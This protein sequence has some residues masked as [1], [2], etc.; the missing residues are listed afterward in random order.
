[1]YRIKFILYTFL[2]LVLS[3]SCS[4]KNTDAT[5][6]PDIVDSKQFNENTPTPSPIINNNIEEIIADLHNE[7]KILQAELSYQN[8]GINKIEAQ[9]Q[10]WA[11]PLSIYNKE[12]VLNNGSSIFGKIIYQDENVMKIETLIGQLM[13]ERKT[14]ARVINQNNSYNKLNLQPSNLDI[15]KI[16]FN[17]IASGINIMDKHKYSESVQLTL[18]GNIKEVKDGSGNTILSGEVKNIGTKRADFAKIIFNFRMDWKGATKSLTAF[19]NGVTNTFDTGIS[20][21]NSI[22]A[23]AVGSFEL[24]IPS[25]FGTFIGYNYDFDWSQYDR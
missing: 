22:P 25:S 9:S 17:N 10:L 13:I 12:I 16:D 3:F 21:N 5:T 1:M 6:T 2:L 14:I 8:D 4:K 15:D 20:S 23:H 11:D 18:I 19:I 7:I 24:I